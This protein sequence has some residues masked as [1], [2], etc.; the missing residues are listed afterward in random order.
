MKDF[1]IGCYKTYK[2]WNKTTIIKNE[3]SSKQIN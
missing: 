3:F 1:V 2:F